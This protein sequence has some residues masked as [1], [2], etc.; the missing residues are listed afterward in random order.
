MN[1]PGKNSK[2]SL[3]DEARFEQELAQ[4]LAMPE[5]SDHPLRHALEGL[6]QRHEDQIAQLEKLTSISDGFHSAL[7]ASNKSLN[8]RYC[9]QIRQLQKII[10]ISDHY[11]K[12]LQDTNEQLK[13]ASTQDPLTHLPNRR[14]MHNHLDAET[15]KAARGHAPF[16]LD[17]IDVDHF[18]NINDQWGHDVG[19]TALV[20]LA[21]KL[22]AD[23]RLYDV[24]ARWGGEEFLILLPET[25]GPAAFE[26]AERLRIAVSQLRC[27]GLP[28]DA[29]LSL[30]IGV[31]QHTPQDTWDETLKHADT[32]LYR[33]KAAGRNSTILYTPAH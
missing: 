7:R 25:D 16:A 31:V 24:C 18:K 28:D 22:R 19:D 10:R 3:R 14:L 15:A 1:D 27:P 26:I 30:S 33:A 8:E 23:L 17:L 4:L 13:I 2:R 5:Y 32:A 6:L 20:C 21:D 12:M 11:Q 9:Q 29:R